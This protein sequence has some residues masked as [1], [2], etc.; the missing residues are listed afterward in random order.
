MTPNADADADADAR[1]GRRSG[2]RADRRV[3]RRTDHD[4]VLPPWLHSRWLLGT[5]LGMGLL[6]VLAALGFMAY[7]RRELQHS[8]TEQG[9]LYARVLEDHANRSFNAVD[10]ALGAALEAARQQQQQQG[11][12]P[13]LSPM[14]Q[15]AIQTLPFL[16]SISLLDAQGRVLASST[17]A[18]VGLQLQRAQLL[19]AP[20]SAGLGPLLPG[21]DLADLARP[22]PAQARTAGAGARGAQLLPLLMPLQPGADSHWLV[23]TINPDYFANQYALLLQGTPLAASLLSY[24]GQLLV[25]AAG[26]RHRAGTWLQGHALF[27]DALPAGREHGQWQGSGLDGT[28][29][30]SAWR[31]ARR[32][33]LV[34]LVETPVA[35]LQAKLQA[36]GLKVAGL[37][38]LLLLALGAATL[39]AWRSL[40][41][42]EA[43]RDDL[44]AARGSLAA[45]DAFTDRLFQVSPI[46]MVVKDAAGRFLRV[47]Q[48]WADLTGIAAAQAIGQNLGRLYPAQLAAPHEAQEQLAIAA[49]QAVSYEEQILDSDGLPRDVVTRVT[50]FA[51]A[52]GR[53]AGVIACLMDVTEFREV[54]QRT[55]EAKEAAERSN[56]AKSEFLANISHELRTPLQSIL[57]FS[58]LGH[59]RGGAQPRLQGMFASI[60]GA[61]ERMLVLVNNLLDL[62]RLES[63]VGEI[64]RLAQDIVPALRA[65][66]DELQG[67][68][69]ARGLQLQL[70]PAHAPALWLAG[71]AFRLQQVLRNLLAN[72]IRFAPAGSAITVAWRAAPGGEHQISVR[73]HGPG[74]PPAELDSIFEAFVQSSR[75][76]DGAGGTGLGLAICRKIMDGHGGRIRA[77]NHPEGG[78]VFELALPALAAPEVAADQAV[79]TA[80]ALA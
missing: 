38:L 21:R 67:L 75:T 48:A 5:G 10:L 30:F 44:R 42:H 73:D 8:S 29:V 53:V 41:G 66:G 77:R 15:Q 7:E 69:Q 6:I 23:A 12:V 63:P 17:A 45:Q 70:P 76:K 56:A 1:A 55:T 52:E 36:I 33:P 34:V 25:P 62:S 32:Q 58:E 26:S 60:H 80:G 46:P 28:P 40:R 18:N 9:A 57:G 72:A 22:G 4:V 20:A 79:A 64:Q 71:D 47:N 59:T 49:M 50:P 39:V 3:Q 31:T 78:A 2:R 27:A 51:D 54:A 65:V 74:I 16:R 37:T 43:V 19:P 68:A 14:L 61:G 24:G 11:T 35:V 13:R